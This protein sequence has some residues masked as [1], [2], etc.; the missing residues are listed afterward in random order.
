MQLRSVRAKFTLWYIGSF[1]ILIFLSFGLTEFL[2]HLFALQAID[3]ALVNGAEE[4]A[5]NIAR[6]TP[7]N[8]SNSDRINECIDRELRQHFPY[9]ILYLQLSLPPK[10]EEKTPKVLGKSYTLQDEQMPLSTAAVQAAETNSTLFERFNRKHGGAEIRLLTRKILLNESLPA[11]L[12]LGIQTREGQTSVSLLQQYSTTRHHIFLGIFP[13]L[14][15]LV[16]WWGAAFMRRVFAPVHTIVAAAKEIT[17]ED[18]SHR[19]KGVESNDEIGELA[20]TL[21]EMIARL[22]ASF[23]QIQQFSS[24]VAHE[25]KTPLTALKGELEVALRK[26]RSPE[27]YKEILHSLLDDSNTLEKIIEDLLFLARM[28]ASKESVNFTSISLDEGVLEVFEKSLR[29]AQQ[30]QITLALT[31]VDAAEIPGNSGLL[32]RMLSNL[33]T[34]AIHYTPEKGRIELALEANKTDICVT[35]QDNG[36]G[37]PEDSLPHIFDRFYRVDESRFHQTGGSGLGLAIVKKIADIHRAVIEVESTPE[38]GTTFRIH[39]PQERQ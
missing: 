5:T 25:L 18:L 36:C 7:I 21:N 35:L 17:A 11:L 10:K 38:K 24:D 19:I 20:D 4:I 15:I 16:V 32:Q 30:K 14:L 34:N 9:D 29:L 26:E 39:W 37:I 1:A 31:V 27:Q 23:Q 3:K 6:C 2:F 12:Q 28:D 22:D 13:A 8:E 33:V